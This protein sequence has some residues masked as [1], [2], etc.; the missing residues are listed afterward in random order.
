MFA[1]AAANFEHH[2]DTS[3]PVS[4]VCYL[5][6]DFEYIDHRRAGDAVG[7]SLLTALLKLDLKSWWELVFEF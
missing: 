5:D 4:L 3:L 2:L 1:I 7:Y 6:C